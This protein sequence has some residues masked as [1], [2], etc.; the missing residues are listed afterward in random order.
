MLSVREMNSAITVFEVEPGNTLDKQRFW[1]MGGRIIE[2]RFNVLDR[3]TV[4]MK[5]QRKGVVQNFRILSRSTYPRYKSELS[6]S[7]QS[8]PVQHGFL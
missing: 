5:K 8:A 7:V 3:E 4:L 6:I 1:F 2:K